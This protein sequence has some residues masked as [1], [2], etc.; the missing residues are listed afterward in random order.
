MITSELVTQ[1]EVYNFNGS[2][3]ASMY[4]EPPR[5][6]VSISFRDSKPMF[7]SIRQASMLLLIFTFEK[8]LHIITFSKHK[9]R[10][11]CSVLISGD[12]RL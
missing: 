2:N 1:I 8:H 9:A 12:S 11:H 3:P 4:F 5:S 7:D 6:T 10:N